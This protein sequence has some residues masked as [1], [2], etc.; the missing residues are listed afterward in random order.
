MRS[1]HRLFFAL[2]G[3]P[4]AATLTFELLVRPALLKMQGCLDVERPRVR[5]RLQA[6]IRKKP[7]LTYFVRAQ[8]HGS[9]DALYADV[10]PNQG[11]SRHGNDR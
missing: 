6:P 3:N 11:S 7:R 2:P 8:V 5:V 1:T 9:A 10:P 4:A